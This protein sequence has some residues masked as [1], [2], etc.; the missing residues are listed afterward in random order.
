MLTDTENELIEPECSQ[1]DA[2]GYLLLPTLGHSRTG[3]CNPPHPKIV[4]P[5]LPCFVQRA[6]GRSM[7]LDASAPHRMIQGASAFGTRLGRAMAP[8]NCR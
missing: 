1:C 5:L 7:S 8:H 4:A 6:E 3:I 2:R